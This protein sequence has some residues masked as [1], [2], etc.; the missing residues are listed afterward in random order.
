MAR[1][2]GILTGG[3]DVPGLNMAIKGFVGRMEEAGYEILGLRRGWAALLNVVPSSS[4]DNSAWLVPLTRASTRTIDRSGGTVLH[5]SRI[6]PAMMKP[7]SVPEHLRGRASGS[8]ADGRLDLTSVA[9][10]VLEFLGL[11]ALVAIGG[12]GTLSFACRLHE[13]GVP[14]VGVP[15][16]MDNDVFGTEYCIGF[17]TAV[18]RSVNFIHDLRT[19]AGSHERFL[20]VELFGRYS[21]ETCLLSSYLAGT[22]RALIAEV[23]FEPQAI[24]EL[25]AADKRCNPSNYAVVA[26]SEGAYPVG[27]HPVESG[28]A[29]VIGNRELGGIGRLLRHELQRTTGD[30]VIYQRLGYLMR[31]G[32]PDALD[33]LVASNFASLAADLVLAGDTGRL[34][35][36]LGGRYSAVPIGTACAGSKQVDVERFYDRVNYRPKIV[37]VLD[38]P[39]F[40]H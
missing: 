34:V 22:D 28:E 6:N 13:E 12:D 26:I 7:E 30:R 23:P 17:S 8:D 3:G 1:R 15:K 37:G 16:T 24:A 19:A 27:G 21:G 36:I 5:T 40:L 38:L 14:V 9:L 32:P 18:T 10:E 39:M 2:I 4:A 20:V 33:R 29:D 31:S 11:E 25:L 35:A